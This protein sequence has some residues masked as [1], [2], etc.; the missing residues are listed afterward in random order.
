MII[1][2]GILAWNEAECIGG[3]LRSLLEQSLIRELQPSG[4]WSVE[5]IVVPNGC[6]DG[7]AGSAAAALRQGASALPAAAFSWRVEPVAEAGKVNAWNLFAHRFSHPAADFIFLMDADIRFEHPDTLKNMVGAL[8]RDAHAAVSVD[9]PLKHIAAKAR[10]SL[11]DRISLAVSGMTQ[12]APGQL[13]GQLY[14]A[15]GAL[16]RRV[17]MPLG[18]LVEDGFLKQML[19]TDLL[20]KPCDNR[21]V[22]RA[23]D[24]SHVFEAY[25]GLKD[26]FF[27]QRRQQI[28]HAVYTYLRDYLVERV[29]EKD[30]GEIIAE[31]N[32]RDPDWFR[33]LIR[34]R[35]QRGGLWVMYPGAFS[36]RWRRLRNLSARQALLR[37]PVALAAF[38]L[39][40]T[41]LLAA[42]RRLKSGQLAGVWKDT[43]STALDQ[44]GAAAPDVQSLPDSSRS[45]RP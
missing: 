17:H 6:S 20:R 5:V 3:T 2:I 1:S 23:P 4:G 28:G 39:D 14:C 43:K 42:N 9:L 19:C 31:N 33:A 18:L 29:G 7:T 10:K 13:T 12:A 36:V 27:N 30:A 21:L 16:L 8:L 40:V 45:I 11:A 44:A 38:L 25:T 34:E 22:I 32:A 24:A 37:F 26:V 41:V 35:M 15:R